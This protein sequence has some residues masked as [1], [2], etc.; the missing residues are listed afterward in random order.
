MGRMTRHSIS[1]CTEGSSWAVTNASSMM[2]IPTVCN[3]PKR[4]ANTGAISI[5]EPTPTNPRIKP[6]RS[7]TDAAI[8]NP[9]LPTISRNPIPTLP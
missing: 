7:A 1:R 4:I 9:V 5:P 8:K 2:T 6:A 3:G